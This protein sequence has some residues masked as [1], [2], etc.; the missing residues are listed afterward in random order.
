MGFKAHNSKIGPLGMLS[1]WNWRSLRKRQMQEDPFDLPL[2]F[3]LP[4]NGSSEISHVKNAF[5]GPEG[6]RHSYQLQWNFGQEMCIRKLVKPLSSHNIFTICCPSPDSS[7]LSFLYKASFLCLEA[8][9]SGW[10]FGSS[11]FCGGS[12]GHVKIPWKLYAFDL[13]I[14]LHQVNFQTQPKTLMESRKTFPPL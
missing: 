12:H 2:F 14:C 1:I 10:F 5:F 4:W 6:G 3:L 11:F 9:C 8:S 7:V 13:L